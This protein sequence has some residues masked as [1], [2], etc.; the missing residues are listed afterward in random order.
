MVN[1]EPQVVACRSTRT[2]N[3]P[4]RLR[5]YQVHPDSAITNYGDLA[6]HMT[7]MADMEPITFEEVIFKDKNIP[8]FIELA[9]SPALK[10]S[11]IDP[12]SCD[13]LIE[14]EIEKINCEVK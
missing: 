5:D 10:V 13:D 4:L 11:A 8:Q 12:F 7:L 3:L 2:R 1:K 14:S 9:E 6:Q